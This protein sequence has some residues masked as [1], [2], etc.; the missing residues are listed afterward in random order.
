MAADADLEL[1]MT[2]T[3]FAHRIDRWDDDCD[4]IIDHIPVSRIAQT[5]GL[6]ISPILLARADEVIE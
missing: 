1:E 6:E 4:N 2:R 3:H 5:L